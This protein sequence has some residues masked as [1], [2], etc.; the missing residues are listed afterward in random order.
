M[1]RTHN[2]AFVTNPYPR[3][4]HLSRLQWLFVGLMVSLVSLVS[5]VPPAQAAPFTPGSDSQVLERLPWRATD[6]A[7]QSL[8]ALRRAWR[9]APQDPQAALPLAWRYLAEVASTGDPR[10]VGY[11]QAT[12]APWW[13][14]PEPPA[15][16][17]VV[18]AVLL[19]FDH[20]FDAALADLKAAQ[21]AQP[22]DVQAWAWSLAI[23]MVQADYAAAA[24]SCARLSRLASA[25]VAAAC[26][27]QVGAATGQ[28][29]V[30][31]RGL[32]TAL[33]AQT[34]ADREER[35]WSLTRLAEIEERLGWDALA[36]A[37]F[38]EALALSRPPRAQDVYLLAA[39]ADHLLDRGLAN[40]VRVLLKDQNRADVLL[41]RL[42][43]A[44]QAGRKPETATYVKTL[45]ERFAAAT[46]RNDTTHRKEQARFL[47]QLGGDKVQALTL[48]R[49]N[50]AQQREVADARLLLEAA[51]A[52][53][54]RAAAAP[55]LGWLASSRVQSKT[56]QALALQL[57]ALP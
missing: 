48:A 11:A 6:E 24:Q 31:A 8:Q 17:R 27:A 47:L 3:A 54:D 25:L 5:L 12:L 56:L 55:V 46:A 49:Q 2:I 33:N 15:A 9:A 39:Y 16:V 45:T 57:Q 26:Q 41:L 14:V 20:Q 13:K 42:A 51:L 36:R 50:W 28:G 44:A 23:Q 21:A 40:E 18:R 29:E 52:N 19:Q 10:F 1:W 43:L 22:D 7:A 35:V 30:A 34:G 53:K 38:E 37:S 32:R 4:G